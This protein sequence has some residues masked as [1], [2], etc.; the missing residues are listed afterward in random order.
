MT[1]SLKI[2]NHYIFTC[3]YEYENITS[4]EYINLSP[5]FIHNIGF[6]N[7]YQKKK[8]EVVNACVKANFTITG[9]WQHHY[10]EC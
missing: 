10:A 8:V 4:G 1:L 5:L 7:F 3:P 6:I 2:T 9:Y